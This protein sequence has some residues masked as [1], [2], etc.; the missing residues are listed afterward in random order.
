M[1]SNSVELRTSVIVI[2]GSQTISFVKERLN[3]FIVFFVSPIRYLK[4]KLK[5]FSL[6][7][8]IYS[9]FGVSS[10]DWQLQQTRLMKINVNRLLFKSIIPAFGVSPAAGLCKTGRNAT[11]AAIRVEALIRRVYS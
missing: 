5:M 4:I 1:L 9:S 7:S 6:E 3:V 10:A 8:R 11:A 2:G